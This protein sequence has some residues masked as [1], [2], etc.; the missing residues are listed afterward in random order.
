MIKKLDK[1]VFDAWAKM[2]P[3][4][5]TAA[6]VAALFVIALGG[7]YFF[8][9]GSSSF[10]AK[11]QEDINQ[12]HLRIPGGQA[13]ITVERLAGTI[14]SIGGQ[15][16][17][18]KAADEEQINGLK[19]QI[20]NLQERQSAAGLDDEKL[21]LGSL[22]QQIDQIKQTPPPSTAN[23]PGLG[24]ALNDPSL[25]QNPRQ[26]QT[27]TAPVGSAIRVIAGEAPPPDQDELSQKKVDV[28]YMPMGSMFDGVLLNGM[29]APTSSVTQ[30]NPVPALIRIKSDAILPNEFRHDVRECFVIVSGYGVL[31][32]ER[33]NMRTEGISCVRND[34]AV[35]EAKVDGYVVGEDG[36]VGMRGRLVSRQ[37]QLIARSLMVGFVQGIGNAMQPFAVPQMNLAPGSTQQFQM[38]NPSM[39][40]MGG[41][42]GGISQAA[43]SISQFYLTMAQQMFPVV[44]VDAGRKATIVLTK[45]FSL[46]VTQKGEGGKSAPT[47]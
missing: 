1:K 40:A 19:Q 32:T 33:T 39:L 34:G 6:A 10:S 36:K 29:E 25:D 31:S 35:I 26:K 15:L 20:Q 17:S 21:K 12:T 16:K 37:G 13:D 45:G 4:Q 41:V 46:D 44:E 22:Q 18:Q 38:P 14:D 23:A 7:S 43:N 28:A 2:P 27:E 24:D 9:S 47:P 30:K 3:S 11:K 8:T 5:R 42:A